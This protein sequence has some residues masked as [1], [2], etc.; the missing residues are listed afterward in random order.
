MEPKVFI[1][2]SALTMLLIGFIVQERV[3]NQAAEK[4]QVKP[5]DPLQ[6]ALG[7]KFVVAMGGVVSIAFAASLFAP[8]A[9]A[10]SVAALVYQVLWFFLWR[11]HVWARAVLVQLFG[12]GVLLAIVMLVTIEPR[13]ATWGYFLAVLLVQGVLLAL[14]LSS[15]TGAYMRETLAARAY[16]RRA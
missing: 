7:R 11:G 6:V 16:F 14:T 10:L 9:R 15:A 12:L 8:E 3:K 13:H 1:G 5:P 4:L 2:L